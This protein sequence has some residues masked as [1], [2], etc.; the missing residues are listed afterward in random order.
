MNHGKR[1]NVGIKLEH[2]EEKYNKRRKRTCQVRTEKAEKVLLVKKKKKLKRKVAWEQ[3][4]RLL[5]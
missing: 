1:N 2:L 4:K 5:N 3:K